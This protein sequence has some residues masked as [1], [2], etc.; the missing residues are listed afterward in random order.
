LNSGVVL[1]AEAVFLVPAE[2][3]LDCE[4]LGPN[5]IKGVERIIRIILQAPESSESRLSSHSPGLS[6]AKTNS[7]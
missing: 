7:A 5:L 2:V 3:L 1:V 4:R 6:L